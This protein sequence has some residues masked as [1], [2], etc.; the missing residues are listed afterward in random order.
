M[1]FCD[2]LRDGKYC[3]TPSFFGTPPLERG[4]TF[5]IENS[6]IYDVATDLPNVGIK[7]TASIRC[8]PTAIFR[9]QRPVAAF[10]LCVSQDDRTC[11]GDLLLS[12]QPRAS[13]WKKP[14]AEFYFPTRNIYAQLFGRIQR[15]FVG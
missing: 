11:L 5:W 10:K 7:R 8:S 2:C 14:T 13:Q 3:F 15:D 4:T 6:P 12:L 1:D 9:M